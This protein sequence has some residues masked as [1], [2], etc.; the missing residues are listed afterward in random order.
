V[1]FS[2]AAMVTFGGAYAVL[3]YVSQQAVEN[4]GWVSAPQMLDGLG[5]AET[6]PGPLIMVLQFVGFLGGWKLHEPFSP[7]TT[8][9]LGAGITTWTTFLPCFLWIFLG[10]PHIEQLRGNSK[11]TAA[12]S[13]ITAAVVGVV[14]NLAVWFGLHALLPAGQSVNWFGIVVCG[15]ALA[16]M[17]KWKWDIIPVVIVSGV[18]GL[19]YHGCV[20]FR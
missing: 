4:Y 7:L 14:M 10:A 15:V 12:L 20:A 2:K 6:T 9:T 17:W 11:L 18:S 13:T 19:I 16:G 8:A 5:L 3:P 1:F